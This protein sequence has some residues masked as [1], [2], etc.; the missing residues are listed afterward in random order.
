MILRADV[1]HT[2]TIFCGD[3]EKIYEDFIKTNNSTVFHG[4]V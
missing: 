3:P 2:V 4:A 1:S